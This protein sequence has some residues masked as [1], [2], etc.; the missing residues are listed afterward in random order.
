MKSL[1]QIKNAKRLDGYCLPSPNLKY[2][3][4]SIQPDRGGNIKHR[5]VLK[6]PFNFTDWVFIYS[7]G[8]RKNVDDNAE[9]DDAV[10]LLI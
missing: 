8:G 6:E 9:A 4:A 5:G 3:G 10:G 2:S 1:L 7:V